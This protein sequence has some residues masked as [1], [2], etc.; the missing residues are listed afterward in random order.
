LI[1]FKTNRGFGARFTKLLK[2]NPGL[3][4]LRF[5]RLKEVYGADILKS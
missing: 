5:S 1:S 2:A 3:K 4:I